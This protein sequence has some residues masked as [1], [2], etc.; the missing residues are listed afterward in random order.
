LII[1]KTYRIDK[2]VFIVLQ[3]FIIILTS[4]LFFIF[5][6]K[7]N[8]N[9]E[10]YIEKTVSRIGIFVF[11]W[12]II[13]WFKVE[14]KSS[15]PYIVF[16]FSFLLFQFGQSALSAFNIEP[17]GYILKT[18]YSE[19]LIIQSEAYTVICLLCMHLGALLSFKP[20]NRSFN[21]AENIS[22]KILNQSVRCVGWSLMIFSIVPYYHNL[23]LR[24]YMMMKYGYLQIYRYG[25]LVSTG[26]QTGTIVQY[27]SSFFI[28]SIF[29]LLIS[30]KDKKIMRFIFS[31]L[32][33]IAI[34]IG[35]AC[36]E[37]TVPTSLTIS[38]M[39]LWHSQI[40]R[41]KT[42]AILKIIV[43]TYCLFILFIVLGDFRNVQTRNLTTIVTLINHTLQREN[44][45]VTMIS[46]FGFSMFPLINAINIMPE[47]Q[48]F[49]Y[50]YSYLSGILAIMPRIF[51]GGHSFSKEAA[52]NNWLVNYLNMKFD[53]GF[54]I[55]GE[56]YYNFGLFGF[57]FMIILGVI[58]MRLL[59]M[60]A[61]NNDQFIIK[62][63]FAAV[64]VNNSIT[65]TRNAMNTTIR[66][67]F[68]T[69]FIP[70]ILVSIVYSFIGRSVK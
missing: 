24:A 64:L 17:M 67:T 36:G 26:S 21:A 54:S 55:V 57:S 69:I 46:Y 59:N 20:V 47:C 3:V 16:L 4:A 50:G 1:E 34:C 2:Q 14:R 53:P 42:G 41:F 45:V 15:A 44:P 7:L 37:R 22:N 31:S 32:I 12:C 27:L 40:R 49:G 58:L 61:R 13:S 28:P 65:F 51:Y 10:I 29:L 38:F 63:A 35:F 66:D 11:I 70:L 33:L 60:K 62:S 19:K 43:G 6:A 68:Y 48:H 18:K 9:N 23:I 52:L 30:Y 56:A 39:W 25:E 5:L 8:S